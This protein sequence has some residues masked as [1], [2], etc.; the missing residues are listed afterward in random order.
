MWSVNSFRVLTNY[1][2]FKD[3]KFLQKGYGNKL[4]IL[5]KVNQHYKISSIE[6]LMEIQCYEINKEFYLKIHFENNCFLV[7]YVLVCINSFFNS[8]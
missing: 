6:V 8:I 3:E 7:S 4:W 2:S 5:L 1:S